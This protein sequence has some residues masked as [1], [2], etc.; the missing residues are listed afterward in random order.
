MLCF[1]L[2]LCT[3]YNQKQGDNYKTCGRHFKY[4]STQVCRYLY[5]IQHFSIMKNL[6]D[7]LLLHGG[8]NF[9]F[10]ANLIKNTILKNIP[11]EKNVKRKLV[12]ISEWLQLLETID[13]AN[14]MIPEET[15]LALPQGYRITKVNSKGKYQERQIKITPKSILNVD[16]KTNTIK[17]ECLLTDIDEVAAPPLNMELQL[18]FHQHSKNMDGI[19][20]PEKETAVTDELM[21]RRFICS[22]MQ[23]RQLFLEDLFDTVVRAKQCNTLQAFSVTHSSA[24]AKAKERLAR[25]TTDSLCLIEK[26]TIKEE[27]PFVLIES[28][29]LEAGKVVLALKNVE[30]DLELASAQA[31]DLHATIAEGMKHV[32][33]II[34]VRASSN[35]LE[36]Q[37]AAQ[38]EM[39]KKLQQERIEKQKLAKPQPA[40]SS[41]PQHTDDQE[42][43]VEP[44]PAQQ[45]QDAIVEENATPSAEPQSTAPD[46]P[47][48]TTEPQKEAKETAAVQQ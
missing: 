38:Q 23:E 47:V 2:V 25:F 30:G 35:K 45:Q 21:F 13:A 8:T 42:I 1:G 33:E 4:Y 9:Q 15:K 6:H 29:T 48:E 41:E 19:F 39:A 11:K 40:Q 36:L 7:V 34:K 14:L 27:V 46:A 5:T 26:R 28:V 43:K 3:V 31:K 17:T 16:P 37:I 24:T 44:L 18:K 10:C 12:D 22:S 20:D 32:Q